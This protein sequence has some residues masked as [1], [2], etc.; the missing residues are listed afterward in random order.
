MRYF[1]YIDIMYQYNQTFPFGIKS[2]TSLTNQ[3]YLLYHKVVVSLYLFLP[4]AGMLFTL[5][6]YLRSHNMICQTRM[7]N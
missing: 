2:T 6:F 3:D 7:Q 1:N 5:L 4:H